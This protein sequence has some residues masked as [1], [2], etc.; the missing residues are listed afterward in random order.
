[1]HVRTRTTHT[2]TRTTHTHTH[3]HTHTY[4]HTARGNTSYSSSMSSACLNPKSP[5]LTQNP[6]SCV[7]T[8]TGTKSSYYSHKM[9]KHNFNDTTKKNTNYNIVMRTPILACCWRKLVLFQ[10]SF[11]VLVVYMYAQIHVYATKAGENTGKKFRLNL[12]QVHLL[13]A[14][15]LQIIV[16]PSRQKPLVNTSQQR[17]YVTIRM[18]Y[19]IYTSPN[20]TLTPL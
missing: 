9:R 5:V 14:D 3:T 13:K 1:M 6:P 18:L 2:H 8:C 12:H 4:T 15:S 10:G 20:P 7:S 19:G 17:Q 16:Y 11:P